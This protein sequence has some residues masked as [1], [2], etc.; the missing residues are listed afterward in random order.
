MKQKQSPIYR[1]KRGFA[2]LILLLTL[3]IFLGTI[4]DRVLAVQIADTL[5]RVDNEIMSKTPYGRY[6]SD[7][8]WQHNTE[9][10]EI[11]QAYPE[12]MDDA[13]YVTLLTL[14]HIEALL[15]DKGD[16]ITI[17]TKQVNGIEEMFVFIASVAS[18]E[19]KTDIERERQRTPLQ[20]F[21]GLSMN[22]ATIYIEEAFE[23]DFPD[24][25]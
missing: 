24:Q 14:P 15:N 17:S 5:Y 19:L 22:E 13:V 18:D 1:L 12:Q 25:R 6:Y 8:Y 4:T 3:T 10:I 21:V 9:L 20:D 16:T 2:L 23:R 11:F 7:M